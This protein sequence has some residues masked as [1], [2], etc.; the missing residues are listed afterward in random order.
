GSLSS[1]GPALARPFTFRA[2][3][4]CGGQV[5]ATLQLND[6]GADLGQATFDLPLG[7]ISF[8]QASFTQ[9]EFISIPTN[10]AAAPYP[11]SNLVSGAAGVVT[12]VTVTLHDFSHTLPDHVDVLLVGPHGQTCTLLSDTGG[13][14]PVTN[15]TLILDSTVS[16]RLADEGQI[17]SGTYSPVN[18]GGPD[19]YPSPAPAGPY[20]S[21]LATFNG[22]DPNGAWRLFVNDDTSG[23][24]AGAIAG[25]WTLNLETRE[26]SCCS[27]D[28]AVDLT[29]QMSDS[30]D[31][32]NWEQNV[33]Y[34]MQITN[35]GPAPATQV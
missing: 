17:V 10:G 16:A 6:G 15:A 27:D 21:T 28:S 29:L 7:V 24:G 34:T 2:G 9:T 23:N 13:V 11:S 8:H 4:V 30:P 32:V 12:K 20:G 18:Y 35:R 33:T 3:G 1:G 22:T 5:R 31:P 14:L 25:G 26:L 19:A